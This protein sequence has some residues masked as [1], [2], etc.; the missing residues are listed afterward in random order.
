MGF[1]YFLCRYNAFSVRCNPIIST[2]TAKV[3]IPLG[4]IG[5]T[6]FCGSNNRSLDL[7][8]ENSNAID[9]YSMHA[10]NFVN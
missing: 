10:Y 3:F 6:L 7:G 1:N 5:Y 8:L 4:S 9:L 2:A